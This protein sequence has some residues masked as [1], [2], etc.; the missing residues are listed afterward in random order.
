MDVF[1]V[2]MLAALVGLVG[3]M[4]MGMSVRLGDFCTLGAIESATYGG[5]QTRLRMW[6]VALA[7]AISGTFLLAQFSDVFIDKE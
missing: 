3:G 1:S 4:V 2:G 6:G 7:V 5:D